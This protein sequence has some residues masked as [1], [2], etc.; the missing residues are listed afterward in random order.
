MSKQ[1]EVEKLSA[2]LAKICLRDEVYFVDVEWNPAMRRM[3]RYI[4]R[5][6]EKKK[7][8]KV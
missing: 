7:R 1:A 6:Y 4:L 5:Y 8:K 3:A 2:K